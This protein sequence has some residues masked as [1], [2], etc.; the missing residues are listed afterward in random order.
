MWRPAGKALPEAATAKKIKKIW[1][2]CR[3]AFE[4][5]FISRFGGVPPVSRTSF[6]RGPKS[7]IAFVFAPEGQGKDRLRA[8]MP[9]GM[10]NL[11]VRLLPLDNL[12]VL[13]C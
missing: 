5:V 1:C 10:H 2:G 7:K 12:L 8:A 11:T 13:S 6:E 4:S 9:G 3:R